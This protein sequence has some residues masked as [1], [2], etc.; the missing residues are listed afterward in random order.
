MVL[1]EVTLVPV[2][3]ESDPGC[4]CCIRP[5]SA[6]DEKVAELEAR[7]AAL[8]RKLEELQAR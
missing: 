3:E 2:Q 8:E 6:A 7:R 5:P 1:T 4:G